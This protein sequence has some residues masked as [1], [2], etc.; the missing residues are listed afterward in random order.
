MLSQSFSEM[1]PL[2]HLFLRFFKK[3]GILPDTM[4]NLGSRPAAMT[5]DI[6]KSEE[7][8]CLPV[9][10]GVCYMKSILVRRWGGMKMLRQYPGTGPAVER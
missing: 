2:I 8:C 6:L 10:R 4:E 3:D 1:K 9:S 7:R 5:S